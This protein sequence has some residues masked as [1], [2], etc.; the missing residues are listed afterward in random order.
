MKFSR[1]CQIEF[2]T[3]E[4]FVN[5][6]HVHVF[7]EEPKVDNISTSDCLMHRSVHIIVYQTGHTSNDIQGCNYQ[8]RPKDHFFSHGK[9]DR[10]FYKIP[11]DLYEK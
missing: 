2:F 11:A 8:E 1:E 9:Y 5:K 3:A 7:G 4:P 10:S 6:L